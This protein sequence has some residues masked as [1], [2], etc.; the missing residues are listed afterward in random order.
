MLKR[1]FAFIIL[2]IAGFFMFAS[3]QPD[4]FRVTRSAKIM[5]PASEIFP[6]VNNFHNWE[7]WS[8]WAKLDPNAKTSFEGENSGVGSIMHWESGNM[9]VGAGSSTITEA[10]LNEYIKMQ[11]NFLKPMKNT[12]TSEFSLQEN[13]GETTIT[14]SMYG[15]NDLIAKAMHVVF[16]CEKMVGGMFD[17]GLGNLKTVV[18][19]K[20]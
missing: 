16:D 12:A 13:G 14:W 15:K 20:K 3:M 8:P 11:L 4:D 5:A 10:K 6:Y 2:A 17:K 18:E 1:I 19:G 9:E 7:T